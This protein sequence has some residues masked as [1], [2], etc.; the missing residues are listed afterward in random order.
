MSSSFPN[1]TVFAIAT[2]YAAA[3]TISGITNADPAVATATAHGMSNGDIVIL[4]MPSRLDQRVFRVANQATNTFQPEGLDTTSTSIYPSGFGVGSSRVASSFVSLSQITDV[5]TSGGEQQFF[6]WI[7]LDDGRQRRRPTFKNA[8]SMQFNMDYDPALA[9]HDALQ[10]ADEA[11][12]EYVLRATL[13]SGALIY[14]SVFVGF[15]GEPDFTINQ[16]QQVV[17]NV[18]LASPFSTRYAS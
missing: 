1:K 18:S 10:D 15:D 6:D 16:N 7:Y 13:P 3:D 14:W 12:T 17:L 5:Q 4:S 2:A 8:R 11:G 9:W